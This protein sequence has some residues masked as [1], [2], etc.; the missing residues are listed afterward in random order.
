[1]SFYLIYDLISWLNCI[2]LIIFFIFSFHLERAKGSQSIRLPDSES[3]T[4]DPNDRFIRIEQL[5][6][7]DLSQSQMDLIIHGSSTE[8]GIR[9]NE[10]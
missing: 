1:M 4:P 2:L 6:C 7:S 9:G 8:T 10:V 3:N 5:L